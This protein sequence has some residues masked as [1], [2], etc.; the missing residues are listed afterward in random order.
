MGDQLGTPHEHTIPVAP[1]W[2]L[3]FGVAGRVL[4]FLGIALFLAAAL[5]WLFAPKSEF[6]K[7]LGAWSFTLGSLSLFGT[8]IVLATLFVQKRF[9]YPYVFSHNDHGNTAPYSVAGVWSGQEGSFLLWAVCSAVFG[10]LTMR[11]T[12][13]YR[14]WYTVFFGLFLASLC[15]ILAYES[16]FNIAATDGQFLV[17]PDGAGLAPALQ[18]YWVIIHPPTIF[19]GFGSLTVLFCYALSALITRHVVDWA[20]LVR[21]WAIVSLT[22]VGVGLSMGGL[23]AYETL[24]WGGFWAWDPVENTSFV[25]FVLGAI[26][27]HG[28]IV[29]VNRGKWVISNLLLGGLPFLSF[30]YGTF[31]TRSGLLGETSVHSFAQMQK[32]ALW[33]L[34]GLG[35]ISIVGFITLWTLRAITLRQE[36]TATQDNRPGW[37]REGAYKW[38]SILLF[39]LAMATGFGMSV[40]MISGLANQF[41]A[42]ALTGRWWML[43][44]AVASFSLYLFFRSMSKRRTSLASDADGQE[45]PPSS[46]PVPLWVG[47]TLLLSGILSSIAALGAFLTPYLGRHMAVIKEPQYHQV[48][49]WFVLPLLVVMAASPFIAWGGTSVGRLLGRLYGPFCVAFGMTGLTLLVLMYSSWGKMG[50]FEAMVPMFFTGERPPGQQIAVPGLTWTLILAGFCYF[51]IA[52]TLWTMFERIRHSKEAIAIYSMHLG[53]GVL[54]AGLVLS[55]GLERKEQLLLYADRP[56]FSMGYRL[57]YENMTRDLTDKHNKVKIRVEPLPRLAGDNRSGIPGLMDRLFAKFDAPKAFYALPGL[58][59]MMD[60]GGGLNAMNWPHVHHG[61]FNDIYLAM[62]PIVT[63]ATE[64]STMVPGKS[65]N[66]EDKYLITYLGMVREGEPGMEGTKFGAK[67]RV[68]LP[69][70]TMKE[71]IPKQVL[72]SAGP[73][74]EW[75]TIDDTYAISL[76]GMNVGE[77]SV[78]V[79]LHYSTMVL[80]IELYYKPFTSLVWLGLGILAAGG[81]L[82]AW[83]RRYRPRLAAAGA[84]SRAAESEEPT[85]DATAPTAQV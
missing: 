42:Q 62:G 59:Y 16:P 13:I 39:G 60:G 54:L 58:Y 53:V 8:F 33:L 44:I 36:F 14:R 74:D 47:V 49:I 43:G 57:E 3:A 32:G 9:E 52:V 23:W 50:P 21:P 85:A 67:L 6:A 10:L 69:D 24:G 72:T 55:R 17:P 38:G 83:H 18:N 11:G 31:L 37:N 65:L 19:L 5:G 28:L 73:R 2:S 41:S 29:Q 35:G 25:P 77:D 61:L 71:V 80:P 63:D 20:K 1:D 45:P 64:P 78:Q 51:L 79:Q 82:A 48:V 75:A 40:P 27:T 84:E 26:F 70:G 34:M 15:G 81:F 76:A 4:V 12:G 30:V 7:K 56:T 66:V 68:H 22:L 46:K